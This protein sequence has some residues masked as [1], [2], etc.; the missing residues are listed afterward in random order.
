MV[1]TMKQIYKILGIIGLFALLGVVFGDGVVSPEWKYKTGDDVWSVAITPDGNYVVAGSGRNVYFFKNPQM[2]TLSDESSNG[3]SSLLLVGG[4]SV[5][6]ILYIVIAVLIASGILYYSCKF[7]KIENVTFKKSVVATIVGSIASVIVYV[8]SAFVLLKVNILLGLL[9][10]FVGSIIAFLYV[11]KE[12]FNTTW[13]KAIYAFIIM[14]V[15]STV[16]SIALILIFGIG[17]ISMLI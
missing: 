4:L 10:G 1:I 11:L 17:I 15:I 14:I 9:L 13:G 2:A 7:A 3:I 5:G 6:L 12:V 16:I 8:I